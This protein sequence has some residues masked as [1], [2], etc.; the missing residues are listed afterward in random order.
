M[1]YLADFSTASKRL[2]LNTPIQET[3]RFRSVGSRIAPL[4]S[5]MKGR[6]IETFL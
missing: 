4:L 1:L 2:N 3:D 6:L 5:V